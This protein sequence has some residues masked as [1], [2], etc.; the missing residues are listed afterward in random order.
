M[1]KLALFLILFVTF[2]T[3]KSQDLMDLRPTGY[4]NDYQNLFTK[5]QKDTLEKIM[6]DYE[7]KTSIEFC[8]VTSADFDVT[9]VRDLAQKWG[10]GKKEQNNG[11][12][13]FF[14]H[15]D[16]KGQSHYDERTGYGLEA[17][18]P[19]GKLKQLE[20]EIFPRTLYKGQYYDAYKEFII[21]CQDE[22][23]YEGYDMLVKQKEI[24]DAKVKAATKAFFSGLL[25]FI[26][27]LLF[28]GGI[29]YIIYSQYK[30]RQEF[31]KLKSKINLMLLNIKNLRDKFDTLPE[32]IQN[33]YN[34]K[35]DTLTNKVVTEDTLTNL[36]YIYNTLL[37]YR[38]T[39]NNINGSV[40]NIKSFKSNIQK[41]LNQNYPYCDKYLK[42]ELNKIIPDSKID[43]L[44]KGEYNKKRMNSLIGV[45]TTLDNKLNTFLN[46]TVKIKNIV[47]DKQNFNIRM[48]ELNKSYSDYMKKKTILSTVKIGNRYNS[49]VNVDFDRNILLLNTYIT[50]SFNYLENSDYDQ[51]VNSYGNYVTTLS[52]INSGFSAVDNLYNEYNRSVNYLKNKQ[53]DLKSSI[54]DVDNKINKSGVSYSR[55][56]TYESLKSDINKCNKDEDYDVILAAA[57]LATILSSLDSVYSSIKRDISSHEDSVRRSSYSSSS[58]SSYS[59]S[60]SSFDGFGGGSFGGGGSGGSF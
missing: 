54:S 20:S 51:A 28:L 40:E 7:K 36:N 48:E 35:I 26:L 23:G 30:K 33:I 14:S 44:E 57:S 24:K 38:Q 3:V 25:R 47:S 34:T 4:V 59:S 39:I 19:D 37:D 49:L 31:L 29:G 60:S 1:K 45:N 21:A 42:N 2:S 55:K 5:E 53:N 16:I 46:K 27:F 9:R 11:L 12:M 22:I 8:L 56:S 6:S 41:Y 50:D 15:S 18:L 13:I 32:D 10:V 58:S 43:D 17:F 52:V